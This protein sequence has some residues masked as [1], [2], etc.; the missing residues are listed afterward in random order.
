MSQKNYN[1][2]LCFHGYINVP[3]DG[4][5][6]FYLKSDTKAFLRIHEAQVIDADFGYESGMEKSASILLQ[7][8]LHPFSLY[9]Q[10]Q[11]RDHHILDFEWSGPGFEKENIPENVFFR[12]R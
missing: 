7:A 3:K 2:V 9:Y 12:D 11:M 1:G 8:G 6:N 10:E 5:Y 4:E